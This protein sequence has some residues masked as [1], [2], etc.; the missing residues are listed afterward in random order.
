MLKRR[1]AMSRQIAVIR[2]KVRADQVAENEAAVRRVFDQLAREQP[3]GLRYGTFKG[4][5]G[6]SFVHFVITETEDGA[7]PLTKLDSFKAFSSGV[8]ARCE[9]MPVRLELT[10]V[11]SYRLLDV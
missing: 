5:D 3:G 2:Y 4:E 10:P 1:Q 6:Q 9:E 7:S 11:G 8:R